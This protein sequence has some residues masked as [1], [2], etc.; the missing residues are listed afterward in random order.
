MTARRVGDRTTLVASLRDPDNRSFAARYLGELGATEAA[1]EIARLLEANDPSVRSEAARA[2]GLLG[3]SEALPRL[4]ELAADDPVPHVR[5]NAVTAVGRLDSSNAVTLLI[6]YLVDREWQVRVG[7]AYALGL[8]GDP[9][10]V[11]AIRQAR[12]REGFL[13]LARRR[14]YANAI[15]AIALKTRPA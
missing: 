8:I 5:G 6:D 15:R 9:R 1:P 3:A 14:A 4:I 12:R 10:G 7:A 13:H 11:D 2:L